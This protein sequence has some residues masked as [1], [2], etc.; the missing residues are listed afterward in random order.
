MPNF[1]MCINYFEYN[2]FIFYNFKLKIFIFLVFACI[3][4]LNPANRGSL[5]TFSMIFYFLLSIVAGYVSARIYKSIIFLCF[6]YNI[7]FI[8]LFKQWTDLRGKQILC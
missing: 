4:F 3:G 5:M 8:Y 1:V 2:T 7:L 6:N